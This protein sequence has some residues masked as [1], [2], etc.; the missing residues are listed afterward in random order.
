MSDHYRGGSGEPLVLIHGVA[1]SWRAWKLVLG[2]LTA[3]RDVLAPRLAGHCEAEPLGAAPTIGAW[4]DAL[5][6]KH[7]MSW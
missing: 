4:A 5:E 3:Q 6:R 7:R 1:A 2:A